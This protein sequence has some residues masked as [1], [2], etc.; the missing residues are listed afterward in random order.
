MLEFKEEI[1]ALLAPL[2]GW[3]PQEVVARLENPPAPELGDYSF[4][5]FPLAR[6]WRKAPAKIAAE[7]TG[8]LQGK[9]N[10]FRKVT[11]EGAYL[12][13]YVDE[14]VSARRVLAEILT[15]GRRYGESDCGRGEVVVIDYSAPNIA[16]PFGIGHLRST[17]IGDALYRIYAAL[18]YRCVSINHL[19]DWG[20]QFGKLIV[21]YR[22]W[23]EE[24]GL[25]KDPIRY[26]YDLYVRF[27]REA[28]DHPQ[29]EE[30]ARSWFKKLEEGDAGATALWKHFREMSLT[31]FKRIYKMLGVKFDHYYGESFYNNMLDS[32]IEKVQ[33]QGLLRE[34]QGAMVVDLEQFNL[35]ACLL[36]KKDGATLYITRDLA[37]AMYR[38]ERYKF[39]Q[40]LYVVGAEQKLHFQQLFSVLKLLGYSWAERCKHISFGLIRFPEGR[41]STREGKTIFLEE[42]VTRAI[43]MAEGIIAE[44]NPT[45]PNRDR[46]AAMVGLGAIKFGDLSNDRVKDIDFEWDKILDFSGETAPYIQYAHAR[47]C[48]IMRKSRESDSGAGSSHDSAC[49]TSADF[50]SSSKEL[51]SLSDNFKSPGNPKNPENLENLVTAS[52]FTQ[53]EE[54][55]LVKTLGVYPEVILQAAKTYK[56]SVLARYLISLARDF[57]RFYH[58]CPVLG[59]EEQQE[60]GARLLLCD[61]TRQVLANGLALLGIEA[62]EEM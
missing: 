59:V 57:S 36:R 15:R 51:V 50:A 16:K 53:K 18:G 23:G 44:K 4:P 38:Q 60:R 48:S 3:E 56:P 25:K 7:L 47:I 33:Q 45:L 9:G 32:T 22:C 12:N 37:A 5:C 1:A 19:G 41:M 17:V 29:L 46:I 34:S 21:A 31:E 13:F 43:K 62:P 55:A 52:K 39:V 11:S 26:L 35:P 58:N 2:I 20:T 14:Q 8:K 10:C 6:E 61:A 40:M 42:V 30:D 54:D 24:E 27:H 49:D 28:K